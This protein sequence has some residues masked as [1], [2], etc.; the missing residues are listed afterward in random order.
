MVLEKY[1]GELVKPSDLEA[2]SAVG[3]F[4]VVMEK[5]VCQKNHEVGWKC[6][7]LQMESDH[8]G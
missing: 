5:Q 6:W 2:W 3:R 7:I 8:L 1:G 4:V